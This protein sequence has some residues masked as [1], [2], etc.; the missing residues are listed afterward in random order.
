MNPYVKNVCD[1]A[2][3]NPRNFQR[4]LGGSEIGM[5]CPHCLAYR[6]AE[7]DLEIPPKA[8]AIATF[9][10]TATHASI[11]ECYNALGKDYYKAEYPVTICSYTNVHS[12]EE[13]KATGH[14]DLLDTKEKTVVDWKIVGATT[15]K[16]AELGELSPQYEIQAQLYAYAVNHSTPFT[17]EYC[18]DV[19]FNKNGLSFE[20]ATAV[21]LPYEEHKATKA[22]RR[23][24]VLADYLNKVYEEGGQELLRVAVF[25]IPRSSTH[26]WNCEYFLDNLTFSEAL[27]NAKKVI[28]AYK[29]TAV[30]LNQED[31]KILQEFS[32][33]SLKY[34]LTDSEQ[35][36]VVETI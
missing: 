32:P 26:C 18:S 23:V 14:I 33:D 2:G 36:Y 25:G 24:Q 27:E 9:V 4:H 6:V 7:L 35:S 11:E 12:G 19:F 16:K 15:Y 31:R 21:T 34:Y 10:G 29:K 30:Q 20:K 17:A 5:S 1:Y 22:I 13:E 8:P 28:A 3:Q